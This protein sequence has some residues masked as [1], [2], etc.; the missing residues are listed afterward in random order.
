MDENLGIVERIRKMAL[1]ILDK[2]H[3][4][5]RFSELKNEIIKIDPSLNHNTIRGAIW[6]LDAVFSDKVSKP[7]K[8]LFIFIK[9]QEELNKQQVPI[10]VT[11]IEQAKRRV[12]ES[13]FYEPFADYLVELE[14]VTAAIKLG[15]NLF[16]KKWGTPDV[17]GKKESRP[18]DI[19][20]FT[21]EIISAEIKTNTDQLITAFGQACAYKLFS[22]RVYL[23]VPKQFS[24]EDRSRLDA[25]CK[26]CG[27]G[28]IT[29]DMNSS[30]KPDFN[31]LVRSLKHEPDMSYTNANMK[32]IEKDLWS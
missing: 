15:R 14:E 11:D 2:S 28:L 5:K 17:I 26:I 30:S 32:I 24:N 21:T 16:G 22:H 20:K 23:V 31:I 13:D 8:G 1:E 10:N 7:E 29:F 6:N 9:F 27:I 25:L 19:V 18:S 3:K 12:P 4:G